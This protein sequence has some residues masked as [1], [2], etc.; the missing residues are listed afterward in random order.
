MVRCRV[1]AT[2][3]SVKQVIGSDKLPKCCFWKTS[4]DHCV[5]SSWHTIAILFPATV[6]FCRIKIYIA[7]VDPVC[8][9]LVTLARV[10]QRGP[11]QLI[12]HPLDIRHCNKHWQTQFNRQFLK[13]NQIG[14]GRG[15]LKLQ[16]NNFKG[17]YDHNSDSTVVDHRHLGGSWIR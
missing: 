14:R 12:N 2:S 16:S 4:S 5:I 11:T 7:V 1:F 3:W 9:D 15:Q 17:S 8:W 6:Q 10:G 13:V